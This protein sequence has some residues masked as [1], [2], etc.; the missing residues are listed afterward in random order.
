MS[1]QDAA[2]QA[3]EACIAQ[4]FNAGDKQAY[5]IPLYQRRYV[6]NI[7]QNQQ[8]W[9]DVLGCYQEKS[10]HFLGSIVLMS[11]HQDEYSEK[12]QADLLVE[13]A[14]NVKHVVDGQQRLTSLTL[15]LAALFWDMKEQDEFFNNL[16]SIDEEDKDDWGDLKTRIKSYLVS[17]VKDQHSKTGKGKIPRLVP[18][19]SVYEAY[20]SIVNREKHGKQ[21]LIDKAFIF[22]LE[23]IVELRENLFP[24]NIRPQARDFYDFYY[25]LCDAL[26]RFVKFVRIVCRDG[27]DPFQVFESL[28][29]TGL[30]LTGADRIKNVLMGKG[31]R[32]LP[33]VPMSKIESKW[34]CIEERVGGSKD[35]ET[36]ISTYMFVITGDRVPRKNLCDTF[37]DKYLSRFSSVSKALNDLCEAADYYGTIVHQLP[38][39]DELGTSC[40][41]DGAS[42]EL[43]NNILKNNRQQSVVPLLAIAKEY[44]FNS[45]FK[46]IA[47]TL[48]NLLVRFKVC[49]K[50]TNGLDRI[51]AEF[52]RKIDKRSASELSDLLKNHMP[53][54]AEFKSYF[55]SMTFDN[56]KSAE[57]AR[58][59]Y[60]LIAIE[61]FIRNKN[62]QDN[63]TTQEEYTLEHVIPQTFDQA[64]WFADYPDERAWFDDED[65]LNFDNFKEYTINSIGNMCLLRRPENSGASNKCF[66]NKLKSYEKP[67][68]DGKTAVGTFQ[69]VRQI[70]DN[71]TCINANHPSENDR[72]IIEEGKTFNAQSVNTRAEAM[73]C[74]AL[75]IWK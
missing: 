27:E 73:A 9:E 42:S 63:L 30:S 74:I 56:S 44:G 26:T 12:S 64:D 68:N 67:D 47:K 51:S 6:W 57:T 16:P 45:E 58:A 18:V 25:Q 59:R 60:Y 62:G 69:L 38:Y 55:A 13:N 22:Y 20:K 4:L 17:E 35:I 15:A 65:G 61:N 1:N 40:K 52:C 66:E 29:G 7:A 11:Y 39:V 49:Q 8:L 53:A 75:E 43:L 72:P 14:Y 37:V 32:E 33:S 24:D 10:N 46:L 21:L 54:A 19:K 3:D 36:F 2:F 28:N 70:K 50:S 23:R 41:L 5:A 71:S 31:S 34:A 48:L